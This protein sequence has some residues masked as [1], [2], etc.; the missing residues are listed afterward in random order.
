MFEELP[1]NRDDKNQ[2]VPHAINEILALTRLG[3]ELSED[4]NLENLV[5][6]EDEIL[7]VINA[8]KIFPDV[9]LTSDQ[10][11]M[12]VA[13]S[14]EL[15]VEGFRQVFFAITVSKVI[16]ALQERIQVDDEDIKIAVSLS[17]FP[18]KSIPSN[19]VPRMRILRLRKTS[20]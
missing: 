14:Y 6:S 18:A 4:Y 2:N 15:G 7:N 20:F 16:A 5:M 1:F 17:I 8:R 19:G 13:I 10:L 9:V 3:T 11:A 12:I